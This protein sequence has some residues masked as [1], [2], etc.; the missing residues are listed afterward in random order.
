MEDNGDLLILATWRLSAEHGEK[1]VQ[2]LMMVLRLLESWKIGG[3][4]VSVLGLNRL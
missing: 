4:A 3:A 2:R 1:H